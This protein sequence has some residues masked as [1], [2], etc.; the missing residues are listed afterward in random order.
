MDRRPLS[1]AATVVVGAAAGLVG[2]WV[3]ALVEAPMQLQ[4]EK[5]WAP[6]PGQK[7]LVG[8]D[9]GGQLVRMPP[10]VIA[11]AVWKRVTGDDLDDARALRIQG[12][13]HY[14]FGA[15][16]GVA[17]ALIGRRSRSA[18]R[19][20]GA[21]GGAVLYAATHATLLPA[22]G[23]QPPPTRLPRAALLWEG[24][25]HVVFGVGVEV[26]RRLAVAIGSR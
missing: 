25:S 19:L 8:G 12:V 4:A 21:P 7:D 6:Q 3:K 9:P 15:G 14:A 13:V 16:Y 20:L 23:V 18:T 10:A 1:P 17:Y 11:K 26:S 24:G 22:L 5:I 2:S